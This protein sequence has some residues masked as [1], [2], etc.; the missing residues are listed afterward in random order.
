M[1]PELQQAYEQG[2]SLSILCT[3]KATKAD[4]TFS[5][6][7]KEVILRHL[8][9]VGQASGEELVE[10]CNSYGIVPVNGN[11]AFGSVFRSLSMSKQIV[12]LRADLPRKAGHGTSGGK[13]WGIG[14]YADIPAI[15]KKQAV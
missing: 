11:K 4:P 15:Y 6:R 2:M 5:P 8:S 3:S 9:A 12:C 1:T 7:A 10:L 14:D 13:L